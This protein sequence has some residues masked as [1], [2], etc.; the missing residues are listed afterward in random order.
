MPSFL[1][2]R[3]SLLTR[4]ASVCSFLPVPSL[5]VPVPLPSLLEPQGPRTHWTSP[6]PP[7]PAVQLALPE[8][9]LC[10]RVLISLPLVTSEPCEK[11]RFFL[12]LHFERLFWSD[13]SK[14][15]RC[16]VRVK[17]MHVRYPTHLKSL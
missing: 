14:Y 1:S 11:A 12:Y 4:S 7:L 13:Y 8:R 16:S 2:R 9:L 15:F 3:S 5:L 10:Q 17:Q 6:L